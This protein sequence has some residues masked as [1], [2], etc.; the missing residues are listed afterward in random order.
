M[1]D[2]CWRRSITGVGFDIKSLCPFLVPSSH[3]IHAYTSRLE[4]SAPCICHH[5]YHLLP[6]CPQRD[7]LLILWD[8]QLKPT[9]CFCKLLCSGCF[10]HTPI[11]KQRIQVAPTPNRDLGVYTWWK[12]LPAY[13]SVHPCD[14]QSTNSFPL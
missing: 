3:F 2:L 6:C 10:N 9:L 4:I 7:K 8:P 11:E 5:A 13:L 12:Y 1:V 14:L